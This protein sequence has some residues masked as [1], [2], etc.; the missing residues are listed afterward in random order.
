MRIIVFQFVP[1]TWVKYLRVFVNGLGTT[2][3]QLLVGN[4]NQVAGVA[5]KTG[6]RWT[7]T[8]WQGLH[9]RLVVGELSQGGRGVAL[10]PINSWAEDEEDDDDG[11][12]EEEK[13]ED[14]E[15]EEEEED[16]E[17]E[18]EEKEDDEE[19][20]DDEEAWRK[21]CTNYYSTRWWERLCHKWNEH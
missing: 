9:V 1:G 14:K 20:N 6:D 10:K 18:E 12:E 16:D 5:L 7:V 13:E 8:R 2:I 3:D 4:S 21:R 17:E 15:E 19:E 11:D